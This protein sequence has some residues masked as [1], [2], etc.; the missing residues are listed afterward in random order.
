MIARWLYSLVLALLTPL[1][2]LYLLKRARR[3][4]EY[5][6]HWDERWARYRTPAPGGEAPI[7]LHAASVGETRAALPLLQA[8]RARYPGRRFLV[9]CITPTGRATAR[10]LLGDGVE[11]VY[12]PYDYPGAMKRFLQRYRPALGLVLETEVWPNLIAA[13]RQGVPL[14]L[15]NARLSDKSFR[16]YARLRPL[17]APAFAGFTGILA[18]HE[19]DAARLARLGARNVQVTG[20]LKFDNVPPAE[21]VQRGYDW[22]RVLGERPVLLLASSRDG[23][24]ALW[25]DALA[26]LDLPAGLLLVIV[27]RHPQ[28]FDEVAALLAERGLPTVRRSAWNGSALDPDTRVLLGDS[29]GEMPAWYALADVAVMGG[30]LL[31]FGCQNLIEACAVGTPVLV[32]PST[33]NFAE[34]VRAA[35]TAGAAWQGQDANAVAARA[36][37]LLRDATRRGRMRAAGLSFAGIHRGATERVLA[38]LESRLG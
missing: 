35:Q 10:E 15:V 4:P 21:V 26:K 32:G 36:L 8:L 33:F 9:S 14:Y 25:L 16:G 5:R 20:N 11:I 34:V 2:M 19:E 1:A 17:M 30:S 3:Q 37:R 38:V 29:M 7:W 24:E 22:R 31:D 18:Q 27:P 23:E 28:R 6:Q 13:C 12:L